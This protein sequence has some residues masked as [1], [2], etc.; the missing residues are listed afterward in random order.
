MSNQATW[1]KCD[2]Q[3][4]TCRDPNWKGSR[5][6]GVGDT[7]DGVILDQAAVDEQR[8]AWADTFVDQC[9]TKGLQA[10]AV[11]DHH[12]LVMIPYIKAA[13]ERAIAI[14][15]EFSLWLFPGMELTAKNGVQCLI[16]FDAE[17]EA[18]WLL[19][20]IIAL[21][22]N[23]AEIDSKTKQGP[24]VTQLEQD[25]C[26]LDLALDKHEGLKGR[27]VILP[28]LSK[29]GTHTVLKDSW[30]T[31]LRKS[32]YVGGYLDRGQSIKNLGHKNLTRI[33]GTDHHWTS[34]YL[35]PLPTSDSRDDTFNSIGTN[36]TWIKLSA[37]TVEAIRQAFLAHES[38][39][40][41]EPPSM[42]SLYV[43]RVIVNGSSILEKIDTE[44]SAQLNSIIGGRGSGKS[45][46]VEYL[47]FGIG[48]SCFDID[49]EQ[50]TGK[51]RLK[52]LITE[53]LTS[54][55]GNVEVFIRQDGALF[56]ITRSSINSFVPIVT[57]PNG[58]TQNMTVKELR[59][60]FSA[61]VYSQNELA[62]LGGRTGGQN[63]IT[64]L[65]RFLHPDKKKQYDDYLSSIETE[66]GNLK[67]ALLNLRQFWITQSEIHNLRTQKNS[68]EQRV[69]SLEK[70][71]PELSEEDK[72]IIDHYE[73]ISKFDDDR[74]AAAKE[75]QRILDEISAMENMAV[76]SFSWQNSLE[77]NG[78][79]LAQ[80]YKSF[81]ASY[82]KNFA[83]FAKNT[84]DNAE[85]FQTE[86][87]KWRPFYQD[88]KNKR[89]TVLEKLS[90]HKNS[91]DQIIKLKD[92][93]RTIS[94]R[95]DD[96]AT[97]LKRY[98]KAEESYFEAIAGL[99]YLAQEK[100]K[101]IAT[102]SEDIQTLSNMKIKAQVKVE[103]DYSEVSESIDLVSL[104]TGS[105]SSNR[106]KV[107]SQLMSTPN[108]WDVLDELRAEA[109][110]ILRWKIVG[111]INIEENPQTP[112][113][114]S[115]IGSTDSI[116]NKLYD[117][118]DIDRVTALASAVFKP[119]S[120]FTYCDGD[121]EIA[122][123]KASEGQR[124][125]ALLFMLL[126]QVGG[127]LIIDQPEGDLDN[128]LISEIADVLHLAKEKRQLIFV[129]HNANLVV[130]G[131]SEFV[132]Y[133]EV[134]EDSKRELSTTGAI[135]NIGICNAITSNME[136]GE[137]AFKSRQLKYG[138]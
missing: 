109:L 57:Y 86:D 117:L 68:I 60:L 61:V 35:Y 41:I 82:T 30:G 65:L 19:Q 94:E 135:D 111:S 91:T 104:K 125:G 115:V 130:N 116:Q 120:T 98:D 16:L 12:E 3:L 40:S 132:G 99:K 66:K 33:S 71:L 100:A 129:S 108:L 31:Q 126:Q 7:H 81:S 27:Y 14:D 119:S 73:K 22:I 2:F 93:V 113:L 39:I 138:F 54:K 137:K 13:I 43:E 72:A 26:D 62:E 67:Q 124:A 25:Y 42:P 74:K 6:L 75:I 4:H 128:K 102:C 69:I 92:E 114:D 79:E 50:F 15:A 95:I 87:L 118:I 121:R 44:L 134:S 136:G 103:G 8:A 70:S 106:Q 96:T 53:T 76:G 58:E 5:P 105:S 52:S 90:A 78:K 47:C 63:D 85:L 59:S 20:A 112:K 51:E 110:S 1:K 107:L 133:V 97:K 10:I 29:G 34:R 77:T 127:P 28:N 84:R 123:D 55:G 45:T 9:K 23:H 18:D 101:L 21:N 64:D 83:Q 32:R 46:L 80:A 48:R 24:K 89:N 56:K 36:N 88:A 131:S 11:T 37:P 17:L 49:R 122:F 38:R